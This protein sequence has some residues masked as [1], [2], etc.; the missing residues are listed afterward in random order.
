MSFD[1]WNIEEL[2]G[3]EIG[4]GIVISNLVCPNCLQKGLSLDLIRGKNDN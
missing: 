2:V 3:K 4:S 1:I